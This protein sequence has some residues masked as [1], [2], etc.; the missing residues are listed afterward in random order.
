MRIEN[1]TGV[2]ITVLDLHDQSKVILH[3]PKHHKASAVMFHRLGDAVVEG[4]YVA[5]KGDP[6]SVFL[7]PRRDDVMLLVPRI[8]AEAT[9]VL[10]PDRDDLLSPGRGV[11]DKK[12]GEFIGCLG[13]CALGAS[14]HRLNRVA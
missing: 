3:L 12:T 4:V 6:K 14:A 1:H 13:L 8:V 2:D 7:P 10:F 9:R 11:K 5:L